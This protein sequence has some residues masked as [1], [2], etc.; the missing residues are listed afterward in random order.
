M[1]DFMNITR[2]PNRTNGG[3]ALRK[4]E[5]VFKELFFTILILVSILAKG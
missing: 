1:L 5:V 4:Y 2:G 3:I